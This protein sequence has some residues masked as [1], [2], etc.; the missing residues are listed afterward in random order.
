MRA[1]GG[2]T[3][4]NSRPSD[5]NNTGKTTPNYRDTRIKLIHALIY[6]FSSDK[7]LNSYIKYQIMY[8][9]VF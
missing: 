9:I 2:G 6:I 4:M 1:R 3:C 8:H 5:M 7:G